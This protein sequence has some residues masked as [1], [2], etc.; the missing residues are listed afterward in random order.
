MEMGEITI[1]F[2]PGGEKR[3]IVVDESMRVRELLKTLLL[4][5]ESVVVV[6]GDEV[7][8]EDRV[9]RPGEILTVFNVMSGG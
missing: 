6:R 5:E 7:L 1:V 4:D 9:V 8:T 3:R 2:S